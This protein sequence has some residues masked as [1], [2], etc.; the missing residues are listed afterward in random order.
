[1]KD[2]FKNASS[3]WVRYSRYEWRKD[4]NNKYYITPAPDAM[5]RIY[6]PLKEYQQMV[7]DALNV[8]LMIRQSTKRK[9]REAIMDFVSRY[10][11]LGL[12]TALPTTPTFID[13]KAV[14]FLTNHF[15]REEV[16]DTE[17]Y[18]GYFFPFEKLDFRKKGKESM[19]FI[20]NDRTMIALAMT[21]QKEPQAQVMC[22]MRNYAERFDW[23][24]QV[25]QDWSF[26][27]LSSFLFYEDAEN[28]DEDTR[29]IYRQGMAAFGGIAPSYH[30]EL[31]DRP[32]IVWDYHSLLLAIQMMFSFMLADETSH[33]T[34]C[35]NCMKAFFASEDTQEFCSGECERQYE[36]EDEE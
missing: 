17:T 28:L 7:L 4:K 12:M 6:D 26:T 35:R 10:G 23:L 8:G 21:F 14:Y 25:F 24:E 5:P 13:Y 3:S 2:L 15:I 19:W 34:L 16:L 18:L 29:D 9:I 36:D 30:V 22:F 33:L 1:M 32:T 20:Q 31:R 11:L 27:F